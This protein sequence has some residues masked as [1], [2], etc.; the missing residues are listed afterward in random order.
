M[1]YTGTY[2]VCVEEQHAALHV[3]V[4]LVAVAKDD[5]AQALRAREEAQR[6]LGCRA[7]TAQVP[8]READACA[9]EDARTL[10]R[11]LT[12]NGLA[13]SRTP[14]RAPVREVRPAA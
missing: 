6:A 3:V 11:F 13:V 9:V 5:R 12:R 10:A 2:P 4:G 14:D 8:V 1:D 7:A